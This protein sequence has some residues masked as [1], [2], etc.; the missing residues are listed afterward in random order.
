MSL[1]TFDL[2][3]KA[4]L[5]TG[6]NSGIGLGMAK[7]LAEAGADV[8]IWGRNVEKNEEALK[9]LQEYGGKAA[10]FQVDVSDEDAVDKAFAD[11][12]EALGKVDSCFA[13]AGV[14]AVVTRFIDMTTK[15]WRKVIGIN[16][17]G[18]FFTF[19]AAS[20]HMVKRGEGG[21]LVATSSLASMEGQPRGEHYAATKGGL[22]SMVKALHCMM[23]RLRCEIS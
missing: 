5:V 12:V 22:N 3:G 7:G 8:C 23:P 11:T 4:A 19:R 10:A 20:R 21:S 18:A 16:L 2:T 14:G 1:K 15:E 6:G 9:A 17:E 13:N